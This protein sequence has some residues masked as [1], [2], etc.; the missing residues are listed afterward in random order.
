MKCPA[1]FCKLIAKDGSV[2]TN[3]L[4]ADCPGHGD[5]D[6]SGCPWWTLA[7]SENVLIQEV[8]FYKEKP[9]SPKTYLCSDENICRWHEQAIL[10]GENLCPPRLALSLGHSPK[11]CLF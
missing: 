2:W 5:I 9:S 6:N 4:K 3:E 11:I 1:S 10:H 8:K 7:C